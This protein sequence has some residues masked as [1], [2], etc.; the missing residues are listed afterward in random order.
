MGLEAYR[1]GLVF[2]ERS[3][4][5]KV[6]TCLEKVGIEVI[7]KDKNGDVLLEKR[8]NKG[9]IEFMIR[10]IDN[11]NAVVSLRIAKPNS[12][13]VFF[14]LFELLGDL[15]KLKEILKIK[16]YELKRDF[17]LINTSLIL[18]NFIK[19]KNEF[20]KWY[21]DLPYPIRC[22]EVFEEYHKLHPE[23]YKTE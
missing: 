15:N 17:D 19:L 14:C 16:D 4:K 2:R 8:Y 10:E 12:D 3:D 13:K 5:E 1:M 20:A 21:P 22:E 23:E 6:K 9:F 18:E 7:S 11:K